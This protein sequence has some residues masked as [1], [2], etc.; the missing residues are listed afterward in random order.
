MLSQRP[1]WLMVRRSFA[2]AAA[3]Y[4]VMGAGVVF[5]QTVVVQNAA[6]ASTG[7]LVLGGKPVAKGTAGADGLITLTAGAGGLQA[8]QTLDVLI[9]V[10]DCGGSRRV[11]IMSR[12]EQPPSAETCRRT[13]IQGVFLLQPVTSLLIDI[14]PVTPAVRVRQ[15]PIP[16]EWLRPVVPGEAVPRFALAPRG[17]ILFGGGGLM[18]AGDLISPAC[19]NV[20]TCSSDDRAISMTGGVG[21]W[22]SQYVGAEASYFRPRRLEASG[23]GDRFTFNSDVDGGAL[24]V[25]G[26]AGF[27]VGRVRIFGTGGMDYHRA[28]FTTTETIDSVPV[29]LQW[30]TEGWA[31]VFG[32]GIEVWFTGTVGLYGDVTR[33]GLKGDDVGGSEARTDTTVT[34]IVIGGRVRLPIP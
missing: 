12:V 21:V 6:P 33:V 7:E 27:P 31:P 3:F 5:A 18:S 25:V 4:F 13:P 20:T 1:I 10:D 29:T 15:G 32:G 8:A 34:S 11:I 2:L 14:S 24:V 19:G 23:S 16:D 30:R 22:F 26:K 9:W 28:T 17:L